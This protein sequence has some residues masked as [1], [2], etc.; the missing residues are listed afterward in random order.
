MACSKVSTSISDVRHLFHFLRTID[1][2]RMNIIWLKDAWRPTVLIR[3]DLTK[4]KE[5][6]CKC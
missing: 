2:I 1:I 6:L 4:D 3:E 5:I